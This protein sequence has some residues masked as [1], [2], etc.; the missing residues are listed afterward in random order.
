MNMRLEA[1]R[2]LMREREVP[3]LLVS[4][5]ANRRY[6][7]GFS[8]S[9]GNL[10]ISDEAAL[11]FTDGR[12][13]VQPGARRTTF[14]LRTVSS[15]RPLLTLIVEAVS[16]LG[17]DIIG[18]EAAHTT[19]AAHTALVDALVKQ[20]DTVPELRPVE[21]LVEQLREVKDAAELTT[22][23]RAIAIT[24]AAITAVIP[25]LRPEHSELQ[26]AWMLEVALRERGAEAISF[27]IIVAA[28]R[29]AALPHAQ[30]GTTLLGS[31]QP[32]IIDMGGRVAG[33]HADLTRTIVLGEPDATFREIYGT[34]LAAQQRAIAGLRAGLRTSDADA[35]ARE[36][37]EAAGY[38]KAFSH[39][40]GHGVGL[41][42]HEGPALRKPMPGQEDKA[43]LLRAG[44]VTSVEPGIYLADWGGVRI[45]DLVLITDEGCEVLSAAPKLSI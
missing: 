11:L 19:V 27:P 15:E 30:P 1:L 21:G 12:Y 36:P 14:S 34:V 37:I 43:P 35:L 28:G 31:G 6:I 40:L 4:A 32:I 38:G 9:A 13:T 45:E 29:N 42:I 22:L 24:D 33:Y 41:Y 7:S 5:V 10:L 26:A 16:E 25:E 17:L 44:V 18:F 2:A 23:R 3:A 39:S 8:G 20:G